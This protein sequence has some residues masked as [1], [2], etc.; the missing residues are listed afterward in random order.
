MAVITNALTRPER[1]TPGTNRAATRYFANR[2]NEPDPRASKAFIT[3][4]TQEVIENTRTEAKNEPKT[5]P[6]AANFEAK[7]PSNSPGVSRQNEPNFSALEN[8]LGETT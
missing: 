1:S 3:G 8:H 7:G 4:R 2:K 6:S 5:K